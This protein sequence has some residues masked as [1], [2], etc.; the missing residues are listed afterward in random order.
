MIRKASSY[1]CLSLAASAALLVLTQGAQA[2]ADDINP[3][4]KGIVG[5]GLLGAEVV[6]L[7][8]A[9]FSVKPAWAYLIGGIVGAGGGAVAGHYIETGA[10]AKVSVYMLAGG[11]A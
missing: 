7:G 2:H 5:G 8:E 1:S 9:A 6:M 11:M 3:T 4:P 10:D